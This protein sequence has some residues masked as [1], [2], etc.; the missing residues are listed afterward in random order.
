MKTRKM[1]AATLSAL[2]LI[3]GWATLAA[4]DKSDELV[5][6]G[7]TPGAVQLTIQQHATALDI[8]KIEME[9]E[10]GQAVYSAEI[11]KDGHATELEVAAD[12]TLLE[13]DEE[14]ALEAAPEAV[15]TALAAQ[16]GQVIEISKRTE[17]GVVQ[18]EATLE[19]NGKERELVLTADGQIA[20]K[21]DAED[22]DKEGGRDGRDQDRGGKHGSHWGERRGHGEHRE[23]QWGK[24]EGRGGNRDGHWDKRKGHPEKDED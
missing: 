21:N 3:A 17:A 7:Q 6:L 13:A 15:R 16:A 1:I 9:T 5:A 11:V 10:E 20:A 22:E 24:C 23:S 12:G 19:Q 18:Y 8:K 14:M 4:A 2:A